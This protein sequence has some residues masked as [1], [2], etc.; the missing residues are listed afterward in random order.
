M[1]EAA[2]A[3]WSGAGFDLV[4][5]RR[6]NTGSADTRSIYTLGSED[7]RPAA[8]AMSGLDVDAVLLSGTGMPSLALIDDAGSNGPAIFSS[9]L[10]LANRLCDLVGLPV[11]I[12]SEWRERLAEACEPTKGKPV[13]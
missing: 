12:T 6:I 3:Y 2:S 9:N 13:R 4:E 7:A 1:S 8:E 10:C 11:P 5:V